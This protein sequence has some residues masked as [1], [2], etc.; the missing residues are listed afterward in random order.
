MKEKEEKDEEGE[1]KGGGEGG[2][3][4]K[5]KQQENLF[6]ND[7]GISQHGIFFSLH[8][9]RSF[10]FDLCRS[11]FVTITVGWMVDGVFC[12]YQ[13]GLGRCL[14]KLVQV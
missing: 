1:G 7:K 12:H 11:C 6:K 8:G 13:E 9:G 4:G 5:R 3:G 14:D 2:V 10:V